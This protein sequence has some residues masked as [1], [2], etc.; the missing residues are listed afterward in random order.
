M[1]FAPHWYDL[2]AL[3]EKSFGN[4]TVNVQALAKVQPSMQFLEV[5]LSLDM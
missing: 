5:S 4:L 2:R 1:V 3:F